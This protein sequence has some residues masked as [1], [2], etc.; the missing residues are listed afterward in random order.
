MERR[1]FGIL[2]EERD[3]ANAQAA[4]LKQGARELTSHLVENLA[5]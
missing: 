2:K 3:I 1:R 5:E 4:I